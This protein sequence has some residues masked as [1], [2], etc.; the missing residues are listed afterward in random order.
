MNG[1][2]PAFAARQEDTKNDGCWREA[3]I[4]RSSEVSKVPTHFAL[5]LPVLNYGHK[6]PTSSAVPFLF[7]RAPGKGA[8]NAA[9]IDHS[10]HIPAQIAQVAATLRVQESLGV[11]AEPLGSAG[12][13]LSRAPVSM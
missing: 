11:P 3:D 2:S 6:R 8:E 13:P 1:G 10:E 4:R 5:K 7:G 9:K 12:R